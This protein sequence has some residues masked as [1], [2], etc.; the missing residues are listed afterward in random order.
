MLE[1]GHKFAK[2]GLEAGVAIGRGCYKKWK[3]HSFFSDSSRESMADNQSAQL[4]ELDLIQKMKWLETMYKNYLYLLQ[5]SYCNAYA[6]LIKIH[7]QTLTSWVC[8]YDV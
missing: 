6:H 8:V 1:G 4:D 2:N 5:N 3:E 7:T